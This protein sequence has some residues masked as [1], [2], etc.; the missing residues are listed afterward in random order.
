MADPRPEPTDDDDPAATGEETEG[1]EHPVNDTEER[2][3]E[4]ESPA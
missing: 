2:Y 3:G 1:A 4:D